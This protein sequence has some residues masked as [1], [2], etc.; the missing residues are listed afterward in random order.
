MMI[1]PTIK[2][3]EFCNFN[4]SYCEYRSFSYTQ[5]ENRIINPELAIDIAKQCIIINANNKSGTNF[6]WHGGEPLLYSVEKF[7]YIL[8]EIQKYA[9]AVGVT[10]SHSIQTNG[11]LI[12]EDWLE[13][14][15]DFHVMVGISLDGPESINGQQRKKGIV[16]VVLKNIQLLKDIGCFSGILTVL[17]ENHKGKEK[18]LFDFYCEND[19]Q[20]VG[21]CKAYNADLSYTIS[22]ETLSE[23]LI[24][25]FDVYM[26]SQYTLNVREF[27]AY[28]SKILNRR[29][30]N[31]CFVSCRNACG[32]FLTFN[33][34][35]DLF[36][37][38]DSY[39]TDNKLGNIN[40]S[41]L[42]H[43]LNEDKYLQ[44]FTMIKNIIEQECRYC[45]VFSI[46]G[47][48][49]YRN[50]IENYSRNYF[51]PTYKTVIKYI[52]QYIEKQL[53]TIT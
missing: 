24:R 3:T 7:R 6:C 33:P 42:S 50:D 10:I 39:I 48:G 53:K 31:Y 32:H 13:C 9:S 2:L 26:T 27:N 19:I 29:H 52:Q 37:C 22:N 1:N 43:L 16:E 18:E 30:S 40:D 46:C 49:C 14:F 38:D 34:N 4:C 35:G 11:Y 44:K 17:T 41:D 45:E 36:F 12:D 28:I 15:K 5:K 23:F 8:S 20:K 25:F 51:C 47:C 21:F